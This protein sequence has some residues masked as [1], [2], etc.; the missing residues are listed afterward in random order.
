[1]TGTSRSHR[2]DLLRRLAPAAVT[3]AVFAL[4]PLVMALTPAL[5]PDPDAVMLGEGDVPVPGLDIVVSTAIGLAL[6]GLAVV[7]LLPLRGLGRR[8]LLVTAGALPLWLLFTWLG[9]LSVA[10]VCKVVAAAAL[11]FWLASE[12]MSLAVVVLIAALIVVVDI[13]SV[14][15]GP[16][17]VILERAPDQ[18]AYFTLNFPWLGYSYRFFAHEGAATQLGV[19]DVI[20]Y[21][22]FVAACVV[23]GLRH[24]ATAVTMAVSFVVTVAATLWW[25]A[26]PALPLLSL[27]FL[28][29]N[30]D[31]LVTQLRGGGWRQLSGRPPAD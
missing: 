4:L 17:K 3:L 19:S 13:Y 14:F 7:Q 31:L 18:I 5:G 10:N 22:L 28:A 29:T 26:L 24:R 1:V 6:V 30:A 8:V 21:S 11:G 20:F 2:T 9:L 25:R 16:T 23:F 15:A 12:I 27:A